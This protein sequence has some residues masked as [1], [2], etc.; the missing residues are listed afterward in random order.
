MSHSH[1]NQI[2]LSCY[3]DG[4]AMSHKSNMGGMGLGCVSFGTIYR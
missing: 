2:E 4:L 3:G 1:A